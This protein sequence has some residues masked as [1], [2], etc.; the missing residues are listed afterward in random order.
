MTMS[1][2]PHELA[3]AE[4]VARALAQSHQTG[5]PGNPLGIYSE[6]RRL[7]DWFQRVREYAKDPA[8]EHVRAADWFLDND[9]QI[10]RAVRLV[11]HDLPAEFYNRLET[12]S[13]DDSE[14]VPCV[15]AIAHAMLA[16]LSVQLSA[17][18]LIAFLNAY[19]EVRPL[20][21]AE[22][23]AFP[24]MLRLASLEIIDDSFHELNPGLKP[25]YRPSRLTAKGR[26]EPPTNRIAR[27]ISA[28]Q[29]AHTIEWP[30]IVD[31]TSRVES[32]LG[33]DPSGVYAKM[34]FETRDRYRREIEEI[35]QGSNRTEIDIA[36]EVIRCSRE[37]P[38]D[39]RRSHVGYWLV[40]EGRGDFERRTGFHASRRGGFRRFLN[41]R[42]HVV[43]FL[44]IIVVCAAALAV[45][46][47]YLA[48]NNAG[49]L[50]WT[51]GLL[52][53]LLPATVLGIAVVHWAITRIIGPRLLPMMDFRKGIPDD[54]AT[55]V[56]IP[57]II[58]N[59]DEI[60]AI[61]EL[62]EIRFLSNPDPMLRFVLLTDLADAPHE[63]E[64]TDKA[65][66]DE[67]RSVIH[68]LNQRHGPNGREP[69]LLL[70]R[71]RRHNPVEACWMGWERKRG[72]L[73][74][75]NRLV[76]EGDPG[77]FAIRIG[78]VDYLRNVRFVIT[79]DADTSLPP[80][81]AAKLV[82]TL[83][84]P[85]NTAKFDPETGRVLAGYT[86]LQPRIEV[87]AA[88]GAASLFSR[89][90]TGNTSIDIYSR[91]VSD[92]YQDL[93]GAGIFVGKGIYEVA[94][95]QRSV[96]GRVP[97]NAVLSHDLLEGLHGRAALATNIVLYEHFPATYSEFSMRQ[98]RWIRGDWQLLPWLFGHS[99]AGDGERYV[100]TG[101]DRWK[102]LD[103]LRRSLISPALVMF[104]IGGWS[105]LPGSAWLWTLLAFTAPGAY[106]IG[107]AFST[108]AR[109][110]RRGL[111]GDIVHDFI[112][113][114]GRWFLMVAFL[115]SDTLIS[116]NAII[117]TLWRLY[118]SRTHLLEWRTAA[119]VSTGYRNRVDR[120]AM[121]RFLWPSSAFSVLLSIC[122]GIF[123]R[124]SLLPAAPVLALWFMAPEIAVW[125]G[126]PRLVRREVLDRPERTFLEHLARRTWLYFETFAGPE[127]NWLPPDNFQEAPKGEVAHR[128]SP[129]NI[130]LFL[131]SALSA[132]DLGFVPASDFAARLR[133]ALDTVDQL[134][135][136]R[137]Q[138]LNWYDTRSL[139]ALE[140]RYVSTVDNGNLAACLLTAAQGCL[141][142]A[143]EPAVRPEIWDG[144]AC[145]FE[146]L[147]EEVSKLPGAQAAA[148]SQHR[149][150]FRRTFDAAKDPPAH[151]HTLLG[152][153]TSRLWPEFESLVAEIVAASNHM[154]HTQLG[155]IQV[156]LER[157]HH[158]IHSIQRE[159]SEFVPW[160]ELLAQPPDGLKAIAD[161]IGDLLTA[162]A[163]DAEAGGKADRALAILCEHS[164]R[165]EKGTGEAQWLESLQVTIAKGTAAQQ[166]AR[167]A[168]AELALRCRDM[169]FGMDF[170]FLYDPE[171]RLF[172]IGY[173]V[174]IGRADANHYDLLAT[175]AR[176]ASYF[177][178]AKHDVPLE[179]WYF[180]GRPITR[181]KGK[182][183]ILSWN[184]SMFEYLMPPIFLP[185]KLDT[186]LGESEATAVEYQ[187][188]YAR[189]HGVPWGISESAFGVTDADRNYQYRAFG[190]PGLGLRRGLGEDLVVAPYAS[191]L[192]LCCWPRA[193]VD[194]LKTLAA[195]GAS[196]LYGYYD[197][198]DF[199]PGR[200][201]D[202]RHGLPVK[203]YMAHHQGMTMAAIAN[204][205]RGDI[206]VRRFMAD[207][208]MQTV[209]LLLQE[210]IPWGVPTEQGR[211]EEEW[212]TRPEEERVTALAPWIPSP[213][214]TVPQMHIL[215]NGHLSS[216]ISES[217]G[218]G[219]RWGDDALTRWTPDPTRDAQGYWIYLHDP[220][221][222]V[223]WSA[224]RMPT[225]T[226]SDD[227]RVVFHQHMVEMFRRDHGIAVR[228]ETTVAP[229]DDTDIRMMTLV[230]EDDRDRVIEITSYAE[231]VLAPPLADERHPAFSKLFVRSAYLAAE[232][233]LLFTRNPRRPENSPPVLLHKVVADDPDIELVGFET[234]R[235]RFVGR[236]RDQ[237][238]PSAQDGPLSGTAGWTLDPVM[239]LR[240][241]I[242][243]KPMET[244][245]FS[246]VTIA[247]HTRGEVL[248]VARRYPLAALSRVFHDALRDATRQIERFDIEPQW[249]PDM[250]ALSS[251]LLNPHSALGKAPLVLEGNT[252]GQ[253]DL[254]Q[255][256][257]SGDLPILLLRMKRDEPSELLDFLIRA[258]RLWERNG[259]RTDIVVL[260]TETAGYEEP[261][262]ER[263]HGILRDAHA[264]GYLD[265]T[266]GIH[267]VSDA[268]MQAGYRRGLEAVAHVVLDEDGLPLTSMLD[269][270]LEH[271]TL[272]PRL[273]ASRRPVYE[274]LE[275][276]KRPA[277]LAFDNGLG[278][279]DPQTG[280]YILHLE[281][282]M[283]T[284]A[285][286]CN[287][288]AND[289]FGTIV[290]ES[291]LGFS[292]AGNSGENRLTP[293]S[294]DPVS[295]T[296]GEV[297]YLRD[298]ETATFWTVTQA[299]RGEDAA[300]QIRHGAGYTTWL[301]NS[302]G[303][304][305]E[306]RAFVP[307]DDPV[308]VV[309][310]K[311]LNR[312]GR[313]R[314]VTAT[315]YAEWLLGALGSSAKPHIFCEYDMTV[316]AILA[317]NAWN[318]EFAGKV[319]FLAASMPP[320]SVT[321]DRYS[322]FGHEGGPRNPAGMHQYDLGSRFSSSRDAGGAYQVHM[323]IEPGKSAE[324]V[325]VLGQGTGREEAHRLI[326][327]WRDPGHASV[328]F[329]AVRSHWETTLGAVVV[330]TPD[331]AFDIMTNRWLVYQAISSR[332]MARAGFYQAGGAFGFRDQLQDVLALLHCDP[333]RVRRQ[334]LLAAAHQF[335][336][337][338]A[339]HWWHPPSGRGVRTH[340]SD[341]YIWL[342]FVTARY[343][344]ATGDKSI[345]DETIPFLKA[346]LLRPGEDDRYA[347]F[348]TGETAT[349]YEHCV[350]ALEHMQATGSHGLP[351]IGSGDWND[352]MDRV[353]SQG[354]GESVWLAWF[355]IATINAF[356]PL[357]VAREEKLCA[358]RWRNYARELKAAIEAVA[359]DGEW[360]MRAF[361]D[362]G[363]PWGSKANDE[364]RI[365]SIAQSWS[366]I[367]G[368]APPDRARTAINSANHHL[369]RTGERLVQLLDPPFAAT[370]RDP[371]YI[372]AYP[373]G[374]RENGGQYT[375]AATWLG[376]ANAR[377][378]DGDMA[379]KIFDIINPITRTTSRAD[380]E[381]YAR[382]PFVVAGDVAGPGGAIG[383]GGWSW[384]TGAAGWTWQL[385]VAGIL[386]IRLKN[387]AVIV[388]PCLP[389]D[390]GHAEVTLSGPKGT[391]KI[392]IDDPDH[393]GCGTVVMAVKGKSRK[394]N[395]VEFP[396]AGK[397]S[398]VT[399]R[400]LGD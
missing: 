170:T 211:V 290:S 22:L 111:P 210:R 232:E 382:E 37:A 344:E 156:W 307:L 363:E 300:C 389:K 86:V 279:F 83:A 214:A 81:T 103:N 57:V 308:K 303:L 267:L 269:K 250:Q 309:S 369:I 164:A 55:A 21:I 372:K 278:G 318:P 393:R 162:A 201:I 364:C 79:L 326:E 50:G 1:P 335:E 188:D 333:A 340:C 252:F 330:K 24:S 392:L 274:P 320:H 341:D 35:A 130:G 282:G 96:E 11:R 385:A 342:A 132:C 176:L 374:T 352:G 292:W 127:D 146:V 133:N 277:D 110:I 198:V 251:L 140:P 321:G 299:P 71:R 33:G 129:T 357:A 241:R 161:E 158:H 173:N 256:G 286:W 390:W 73:E 257:I 61:S 36:R 266:G 376:I 255:F 319:A 89:L 153:L 19:Q 316:Q 177:A 226:R 56:I 2:P 349:L 399:V 200:A 108:I 189:K 249:L 100:L 30:D 359:W 136:Y 240:L 197:S 271:R 206:L 152:E 105:L 142:L 138:I 217:G 327:K 7:P 31:R 180:L 167:A 298:E 230:N 368:A 275:P 23:W 193:A 185:R 28:L 397:T 131:T 219:L 285:P 236:N 102:I 194:N 77:D 135:T 281:S 9:Y 34:N 69:F 295:D 336:E 137:G 209:E 331:P 179:H 262:R 297:L 38:S 367:S 358:E 59:A 122:L 366:V 343:V 291:G 13:L 42:P 314:R 296:P 237:Q 114:G 355:Q 231:V 253:P 317:N 91:A 125:L 302:H 166:R 97:E 67:L 268:N 63:R 115:I 224:G 238:H 183:S 87:L 386:G 354:R 222:D 149:E 334:I 204:V 134:E 246:F 312:T 248:E 207:K 116:L 26:D 310:L 20:A 293:W 84:H 106:L 273:P 245:Q 361:D 332:L 15:F 157:F 362:S 225:G 99:V 53:S 27:A 147:L 141:D 3:L 70:H 388:E 186:L 288:L 356:A 172:R 174:S 315:Y 191:A 265:R 216:L 400:I 247:G 144:L 178:I 98:H 66:E 213:N 51:F 181:L 104:F 145:T 58:A 52:L 184:G 202:D 323:D 175:E 383:Q 5:P 113:R 54:C 148:L 95:F 373:P 107:E 123:E 171:V 339:Q 190:A 88:K 261:L 205:L 17:N 29:I 243:L 78:D 65:I 270:V 370:A 294:N 215:G 272:P 242:R 62:L 75:F 305:Q 360:Y 203:T 117:K 347:Q 220:E 192:A 124:P 151:W 227:A 92:V 39:P 258:Q 345:L 182:P 346:E 229:H 212:K 41:R 387:G 101:L 306:L 233:G 12:L 49:P 93:F 60:P 118:F 120:A 121:W 338:D 353:G 287:V 82:G 276:P 8:P 187:R 324:V 377:L 143:S 208:A 254:W 218:G 350:R 337:G 379:W 375:H 25:P 239:A 40:G 199:T 398:D 163:A 128:T 384:Y 90:Y 72:K 195:Q 234:D 365:D 160:L 378:G 126:R 64:T 68:S 301:R 159:F 80:G 14:T 235:R 371:G 112:D 94:P 85:L 139:T 351:L 47:L 244:K 165:S 313:T 391:L 168:L 109:D 10:V 43:Y 304:E 394:G 44:A 154:P 76:L 348:D 45:P 32:V 328:S 380:A 48:A 169:A 150:R 381:L 396:G 325:F 280:D 46:V 223:H 322:F 395:L 6:L 18:T 228:M 259:F 263:I 221:L 260:R 119:H 283:Q 289:G 74:Q 264:Y 196:G 4:D 155:G 329:E 284:P 16:S 311:L